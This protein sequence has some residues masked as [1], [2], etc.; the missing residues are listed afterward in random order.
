MRSSVMHNIL[1]AENAAFVGV[2]TAVVIAVAEPRV[3]D[4]LVARR[5]FGLTP[6]TPRDRYHPNTF[7]AASV[8]FNVDV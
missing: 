4:A 2:I 5:T 3:T 1:T 6:R 8:L 7:I